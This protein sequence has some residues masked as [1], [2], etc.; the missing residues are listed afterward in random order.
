MINFKKF[1][2]LKEELSI[3][4][5][6]LVSNWPRDP[7]AIRHTDHY[8]GTGNDSKIEHLHST[9]NKSETH[10]AIEKH[11]GREIEP[12]EYKFGQI[13]D[14]YGRPTKIGGLLQKTK[15]P[16]ELVHGFANDNTRQGNKFTGLTVHTTRSPEGVAGQT[17]GDQS[18][19]DQS[20]K[21]FNSGSNRK[22]L[23]HEIEHG[24]VVSYLKDH[25][26]KELARATFQ[27]Y[28]NDAG[29]RVYKKN[30]HYGI[31]HA[32]F[33][34]HN[35]KTENELSG[36]KGEGSSIYNIHP[37]VYND[38]HSSGLKTLH[39]LASVDELKHHL[40]E[41]TG[42]NM[43]QEY[44]DDAILRSIIHHRNADAE[45]LHMALNA[46]NEY[47]RA[48]VMQS[49]RID[50][51][52]IE[53]GL[54]DPSDV[55]QTY[56]A[57]HDNITH[58]Q[59]NRILENPKYDRFV[60]SNAL[61]NKKITPD[62]ILTALNT[63]NQDRVVTAA[64]IKHPSVPKEHIDNAIANHMN[65]MIIS[66]A[67]GAQPNLASNQIHKMLDTVI[68]KNQP[69]HSVLNHP[70]IDDS[71]LKRLLDPKTG[72][73]SKHILFGTGEN[74]NVLQTK[75]KSHHIMAVT[76]PLNDDYEHSTKV[77]AARHPA[78]DSDTLD[79]IIASDNH[80]LLDAVTENPNLQ[81]HHIQKILEHP[82][83]EHTFTR[84]RVIEHKNASPKNINTALK[85]RDA[86]AQESALKSPHVTSEHLHDILKNHPYTRIRELA[87]SH[88]NATVEHL[89]FAQHDED[90]RVRRAALEHKNADASVYREAR[91]DDIAAVKRKKENSHIEF[92]ESV[93][94]ITEALRDDHK[95]DVNTWERD[96]KAIKHTDH[97]FGIG[98]DE[99]HEPLE[100]TMDKSEIHRS[101]EHHL[102]H[103]I[104]PMHYK[105]GHTFD[106]YNRKVRI[107]AMLQKAKAPDE[108]VK[109]FA[110]DSTRQ[111]KKY[112][113]FHV[114]VTRSPEGVAGQTSD[115]QSWENESCK[116]I[117]N[118]SNRRYLPHE[119]YHGTVVSYL[120][121][122]TGKE[123]ARA[124]HQPYINDKGHRMYKTNSYYGIRHAGFME[125]NQKTDKALS[126]PHKGGN[127]KYEIHKN[128]YDDDHGSSDALHP[129]LTHEDLTKFANSKKRNDQ[130][131]AAEHD[132]TPKNLLM[133]LSDHL[134]PDDN[135]HQILGA[136]AKN[137]N[138]TPDVID[139]VLKHGYDKIQFNAYHD[140]TKSP[141]LTSKH[142]DELVNNHTS[143]NYPNPYLEDVGAHKN[144]TDEQ[145]KRWADH[146]NSI[147]RTGVAKNTKTPRSILEKLSTD[148]NSNVRDGVAL[149]DDIDDG[150]IKNIVNSTKEHTANNRKKAKEDSR[151][152]NPDHDNASAV[153]AISKA[154]KPLLDEMIKH[155]SDNDGDPEHNLRYGIANNPNSNEDHLMYAAESHDGLHKAKLLSHPNA[156]K[157]LVDHLANDDDE[158][159]QS[160][161]FA[162]KQ[163]VAKDKRTQSRLN[164]SKEYT[165]IKRQAIDS[166]FGLEK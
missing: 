20:C 156:T 157:K 151:W 133:Q 44:G 77:A 150:L 115:G 126:G 145:I 68:R 142:L 57:M 141:N 63:P 125:H 144:A 166:I 50:S 88:P 95:A 18:W 46:K 163:R 111:G 117:N 92:G 140:I 4:D 146:P 8:F 100:G 91:G 137:K 131:A 162:H 98:N 31:K 70:N 21:N 132:N 12:H 17:S 121:D 130:L 43:S 22:Y 164:R 127:P 104:E 85:M 35:K 93:E 19:A 113:G 76:N 149:R 64:A 75:I 97:Y 118:G 51:S 34:E 110:N 99:R 138:A 41:D 148:E 6:Q 103:Q 89:K 101:I 112:T 48:E 108:L 71:H 69:D 56:A 152:Y 81:P 106:K 139:N 5:K 3:E 79:S 73:N 107:G 40:K 16:K 37:K 25:T 27:P 96:P 72:I 42:K 154:S 82:E 54:N 9:V 134:H 13:R 55:V 49:P 33:M 60:K 128:V 10:K 38:L 102:G 53:R 119:V 80:S 29:E 161:V 155:E 2:S 123:I 32:G 78:A 62:H 129:G 61:E 47:S 160:A 94:F 120:H 124:T 66:E 159:V 23:P 114:R 45:T 14:Q 15:A 58:D 36:P 1:I 39:P 28:T 7:E 84:A 136:V 122:H 165:P 74:R 109:G 52:H 153:T 30:S 86:S 116:N 158:Y 65:T 83:T 26:G 143:E 87:A 90:T 11:L 105:E 147:V 67:L 24:T 59:L 135:I